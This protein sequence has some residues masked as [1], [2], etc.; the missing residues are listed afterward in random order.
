LV[1][2]FSPGSNFWISMSFPATKNSTK[3]I[4]LPLLYQN[5][6]RKIWMLS[7]MLTRTNCWCMWITSYVITGTRSKN[8]LSEN[9]TRVPDSVYSQDFSQCDF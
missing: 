4:S 3:T 8:I 9:K 1:S 6:R 5:Y 7:G 2:I